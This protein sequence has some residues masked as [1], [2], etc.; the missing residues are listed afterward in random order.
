MIDLP[1]VQYEPITIPVCITHAAD[2]YSLPVKALL[3]VWLT[4]G[5]NIGTKSVNKNGTIDYGPM[6]INTVWAK[7]L[8]KEFG[9]NEESLANDFCTSFKAAAY[10]LRFHINNANGDFWEGIGN[11]HSKTPK[12]KYPYIK[13]VYKNSLR[14]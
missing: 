4:E 3:A 5:G 9:I 10:I 2:T 13:R 8:N 14:F 11:Y 12:H 1:P 7:K 6:Q